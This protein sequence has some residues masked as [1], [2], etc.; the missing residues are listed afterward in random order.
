[1]DTISLEQ[2]AISRASK[3]GIGLDL[4][5]EIGKTLEMNAESYLANTHCLT[6]TLLVYRVKK[7]TIFF[8]II[9]GVAVAQKLV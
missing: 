9:T 1:M 7:N 6:M 4:A 8:Y 2:I 3:T 5:S